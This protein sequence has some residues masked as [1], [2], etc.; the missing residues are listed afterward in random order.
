MNKENEES[1]EM[2]IVA[3]IAAAIAAVLDR[4]HRVVSVQRVT[5][6]VPHLNVWAYEGRVEHSMS[7]RLR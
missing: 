3:V 2:E 1:V 7:H 4:P 5:I 6:P